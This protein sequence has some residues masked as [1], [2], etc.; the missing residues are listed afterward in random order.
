MRSQK[1][2]LDNMTTLTS[3]IETAVNKGY[4]DNFRVEKD[5]LYA[6]ETQIHY[7]PN[8]VKIDNF[9]RFEGASDPQD[10]AILYCIETHDGIKGTVVD[11]Y[12]AAADELITNFIKEVEEIHKV[13]A[14]K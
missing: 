7:L 4:T 9:Y 11:S 13:E 10:N 3:L 1:P 8:E 14:E 6:P 12:G 5:G 2:A